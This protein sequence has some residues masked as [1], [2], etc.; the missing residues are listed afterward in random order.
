MRILAPKHNSWCDFLP[1]QKA[2]SLMPGE[3]HTFCSKS[4]SACCAHLR[5]LQLT[6]EVQSGISSSSRLNASSNDC[7]VG[8]SRTVSLASDGRGRLRFKWLIN[9]SLTMLCVSLTHFEMGPHSSIVSHY[10]I[11]HSALN[12]SCV[13]F[14]WSVQTTVCCPNRTLQHFFRVLMTAGGSLLSVVVCFN[15][16]SFNF[17]VQNLICFPLWATTV[18]NWHLLVSVNVSKGSWKLGNDSGTF[19]ATVCLIVL[20]DLCSSCVHFQLEFFQLKPE[21]GARM[22][23]RLIHAS[24]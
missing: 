11:V 8:Q 4:A 2:C 10:Y 1:P 16:V 12:A 9:T 22:S 19:H 14:L 6:G 5:H 21:S 17:H 24:L 23:D 13:R 3:V 15:C 18:P 20:K 7:S